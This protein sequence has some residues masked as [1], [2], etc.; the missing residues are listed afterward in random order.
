MSNAEK[1]RVQY[2]AQGFSI[3]NAETGSVKY[4]RY[5]KAP[6]FWLKMAAKLPEVVLCG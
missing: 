4:W 6:A 3:R 2:A 1:Y 5:D